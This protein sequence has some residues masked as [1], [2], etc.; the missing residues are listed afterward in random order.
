MDYHV[1][2]RRIAV[3]KLENGADVLNGLEAELARLGI[4]NGVILIGIGSTTS[5]HIHV[6]D[7]LSLPVDNRYFRADGPYD[8]VNMQGYVLEG[9]VHAHISLGDNR[10][11]TQRGGH[12]EVGCR[13]LTFC[14]I[15]VMETTAIPEDLDQA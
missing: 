12:L 3:I 15:T 14:A 1:E 11:G 9:R 10:D 5:Y 7:S 13:V 2:T 4:R 6:V 8:I